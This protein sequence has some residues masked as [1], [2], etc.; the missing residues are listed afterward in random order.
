MPLKSLPDKTLYGVREG[1]HGNTDHATSPSAFDYHSLSASK[2][3]HPRQFRSIVR[4]LKKL[5]TVRDANGEFVVQLIYT[6]F[7]GSQPVVAYRFTSD[8]AYRQYDRELIR[9]GSSLGRG[10]FEP[11][12]GDYDNWFPKEEDCASAI[13]R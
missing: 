13:Q 10:V 2:D 8:W 4:F 6:R 7:T 5:T 1:W 9:R 12:K 11:F 3:I